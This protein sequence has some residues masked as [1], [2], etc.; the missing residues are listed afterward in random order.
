MR[1]PDRVGPTQRDHILYGETFRSEQFDESSNRI[2]G[3]REMAFDIG[4]FRDSS[5]FTAEEYIVV[6]PTDHDEEVTGGDG[7]YIGAGDGVRASELESS[8]GSNDD[9]ECVAREW[10]V[11]IGV[12]LGGVEGRGGDEDGGVAAVGKE[13]VVEE[14]AQSGGRRGRAGDL[15]VCDGV[16]HDLVESWA[17]FLI[18]VWV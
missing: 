12:A 9:V 6:W 18:I 15:L 2:G 17:R 1:E 10:E 16:L 8:L 5:V 13:A 7:E 4:R 14:E 3:S 11:D